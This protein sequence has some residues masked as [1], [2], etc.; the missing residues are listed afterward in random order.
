MHGLPYFCLDKEKQQICLSVSLQTEAEFFN[1]QNCGEYD[2]GIFHL[3][4]LSCYATLICSL[5]YYSERNTYT[6]FK[7]WGIIQK[8]LGENKIKLKQWNI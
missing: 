1:L 3:I 4:E 5:V 2:V 7:N 6:I 8:F